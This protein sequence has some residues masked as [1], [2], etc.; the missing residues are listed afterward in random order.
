MKLQPDYPGLKAALTDFISPERLIDDP[1]YTLA[2]G[3]D[4]SFY[5]LLPQLVVKVRNEQEVIQLLHQAAQHQTP[6]TFRA[7]GT[8]LSGQAISDSVLAVLDGDAWRDF[9]VSDNAEKIRLQPGIIGAQANKY[10]AGKQR[11]IGPDP[12][13]IGTCKIG[14]IAANNASGMCCGVAQNSYQTLDSMR[15]VLAD[16]SVLDTA[17][18]ESRAAFAK[19]HA[20]LLDGLADM[21]RRVCFDRSLSSRIRNKYRIK[22]TTGY[23]LNALIDFVDPIDILQHL[24]IGSEGTLGFIS[25]IT[26]RTVPEH[27]FKASALVFLADI[28]AACHAV[29]HLKNE[30]V[31][32]VEIMDRAALRSVQDDPGMP[33]QLASLPDDAAALLIESRAADA[34]Q[35]HQQIARIEALLQQN[36]LIEPAQFSSEPAQCELLWK[37]RKGM[38]PSVGAVRKSGTAVVIE[39]VAFPL[40]HLAAATLA[41]QSLFTRHGYHNAIIFG[42]ALEGNLHFVITPDFGDPGEV[43]RYQQFMDELCH[44]VVNEYEGSLKAEHSTGRNIAPYVE[45]EWGTAAYQLMQEIKHLFDPQGL[46]NPGVIL[47][48]DE[49]VHIS[50]LKP[51]PSVD[52]LIDRCIECGFCEP[53]CPSRNLTLTPRQR[54][55]VLRERARLTA[56]GETAKANIYAKTFAY[57]VEHTCAG[58]GLCAQRCPVG[59]DTGQMVRELRAQKRSSGEKKLAHWVGGHIAGSTAI[60]SGA[61]NVLHHAGRMTGFSPLEKLTSGISSISGSRLP[62][63]HRWLP[64]GSRGLRPQVTQQAENNNTKRCVYFSACVSRGMGTASCDTE[65]RGLIEVMHALLAKAGYQV[66]IP[67]DCNSQC[68][69]MPF[70]SKGLTDSALAAVQRLQQSLWEASEHGRLPIVCDTSPCTARMREK[71]ECEM[72]IYEPVEFIHRFMLPQMRLVEKVASIALHITCSARKMGLENDFL[73]L[74]KACANEVIVAEEEGCCGFAG[75]KGFTLPELNASALSRLRDQLP[76]GCEQGYS[77]SLTCEIGLS[78]HT[79]IPFRSLAYLVDQCYTE[80]TDENNKV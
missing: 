51:M 19:S 35:L 72:Q 27:P 3:T 48:S 26:Y 63:W 38:F 25:E 46:L 9:H 7:A 8:S 66:V 64:R 11:K 74:A 6:V 30:A 13:S 77:N 70:K 62:F 67:S 71:F 23:S 37:V 79:G 76:P 42:H 20:P 80:A 43:E 18:D 41:L 65:S 50:N 28:E 31:D 32:A 22:N 1:L 69:G 58:D 34:G 61:L 59:I 16:G 39:D 56:V 36:R 60:M 15:L 57:A 73:V 45:L 47:N 2:Y 40:S 12:A 53:I 44:L 49:Q 29:A 54:I 21:S 14:G 24:M 55:A 52:P 33:T 5:R 4:A 17:D 75:D 78:R 10:L 68:C